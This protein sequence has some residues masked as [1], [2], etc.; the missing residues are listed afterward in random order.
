M[1]LWSKRRFRF[2]IFIQDIWS[3]VVG[4]DFDGV[5][6]KSQKLERYKNSTG[7]KRSS[8]DYREKRQSK[9]KMAC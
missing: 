3:H 5:V 9:I 1:Q 8:L 2:H 6:K 7:W 4:Q